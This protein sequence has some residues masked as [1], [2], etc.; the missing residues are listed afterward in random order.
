MKVEKTTPR[1]PNS[2]LPK[3]PLFGFFCRAKGSP[4]IHQNECNQVQHCGGDEHAARNR[5]GGR[6]SLETQWR[7][8]FLQIVDNDNNSMNGT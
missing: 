8:A 6:S 2:E 4:R 1:K 5:E 3:S 7:Y